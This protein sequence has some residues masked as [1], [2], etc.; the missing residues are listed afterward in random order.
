MHS[1]TRIMSGVLAALVLAQSATIAQESPARNASI[2]AAPILEPGFSDAVAA[3]LSD[4][5]FKK[6]FAD[7]YLSETDIEP[8]VTVQERDAM[9]K[10]LEAIGKNEIDKAMQLLAKNRTPA[11]SAVFDFTVANVHF[12]QEQFEEA[13]AAYQAAVAKFPKFRRAYR[14]IALIHI[15]Q[16]EYDKALAPL[17]KVVELGGGDAITYGLLGY[18]Y[19]TVEN[20]LAAE[21]AY[22]MAILLDPA[23]LDWKMGL[24][25]SF[26]KQERFTDAAALCSQ[27]IAQ[28]PDR[29]DLWMLQANAYLGL[30]QP[31]KAAE[32]YELLDRM[33]QSTVDSL[34][35]L[36]DIYINEE[37]F[38]VAVATYIRALEKKPETAKP[39]RVIRAAKVLTARGALQ[40]TRALLDRVDSILGSRIDTEARKDIL[41]IRARIAVADGAGDEEARVLEEI[42]KL[43]PLDGEALILLGQYSGRTN[44]PEKAVF[45]FERAASL[46]KYEADAKVRHAQLLVGKG[47]YEEALPLLRRAQMIKPRDNIQQ[48]LDQVERVAKAK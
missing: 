6:R 44:N 38:D 41:K 21:S 3:I 13:V 12:Q 20:S 39:D 43:D 14:N 26:F 16:K 1:S 33:G 28:F 48:Y 15:R 36:G 2:P 47:K 31:M 32:N 35:N 17:T 7:S 19:T 8:R 37:L 42:V 40:E 9:Q 22:R 4:A 29:A 24:A 45:Y 27:L 25:R 11:H 30:N 46:E 5:E 23:T 10:V 18:A 34:N